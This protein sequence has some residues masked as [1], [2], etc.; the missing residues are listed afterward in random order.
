[1]MQI[2]SMY[3]TWVALSLVFLCPSVGHADTFSEILVG[4]VD[5]HQ[6]S[7]PDAEHELKLVDELDALALSTDDHWLADYWAS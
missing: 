7:A 4:I 5:R 2:Q 1:M 6:S 3:K